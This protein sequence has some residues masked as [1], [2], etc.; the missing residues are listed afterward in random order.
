MQQLNDLFPI[1]IHL[2]EINSS[3]LQSIVFATLQTDT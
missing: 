3:I 2:I 1:L